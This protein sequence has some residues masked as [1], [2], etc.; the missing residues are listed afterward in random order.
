[1]LRKKLTK[2]KIIDG[3]YYY[4]D[5]LIYTERMLGHIELAKKLAESALSNNP[6]HVMPRNEL[7]RIALMEGDRE[8]A[9][10]LIEQQKTFYA[11]VRRLKTEAYR[12][13]EKSEEETLQLE[14]MLDGKTEIT[15]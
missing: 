5:T 13:Y 6:A 12:T 9:K 15:K 10:K 7:I 11:K 3:D 4:I 14:D 1:M 8:K 2:S